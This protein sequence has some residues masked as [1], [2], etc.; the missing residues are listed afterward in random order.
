MT[1]DDDGAA[2]AYRE[3]ADVIRSFADSLSPE[4]AASFLGAEPVR[5]T[6]AT[7]GG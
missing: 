1:R 3:A 7:A 2:I 4:H 5:E 6:L